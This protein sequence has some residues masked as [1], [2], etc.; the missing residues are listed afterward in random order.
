MDAFIVWCGF[1]GGW[2]LFAGPVHQAALELH[3]QDLE[4]E[5]IAT[6]TAS[7]AKPARV[8]T[9]WWLLPP[10]RYLLEWRLAREHRSAMLAALDARDLADL[11]QY[12]NKARGWLLVGLGGLLLAINETWELREHY[13]WPVAVFWVL[14]VGLGL[15]CG[16]FTAESLRRTRQTLERH[17][18]ENR[19]ES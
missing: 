5:R 4:R 2:L 10:V 19:L 9:W 16:T 3:E 17:E 11:L 15:G 8:S 12:L 6:A 18:A 1:V 7:V 14:A 13:E